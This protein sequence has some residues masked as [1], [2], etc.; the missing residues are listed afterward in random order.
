MSTKLTLIVLIIVLLVGT[1]TA[2]AQDTSPE[3]LVGINYSLSLPSSPELLPT[4]QQLISD[5]RMIGRKVST[6]RLYN[7]PDLGSTLVPLADRENIQVVLQ[8]WLTG[9]SAA[10]DAE[11]AAAIEVATANRNVIGVIVGEEVIS[12]GDLEADALVEY[13]GQ[14]RTALPNRVAVGYADQLNEWLEH[15]ELAEAVDWVG[16]DSLGFASCQTLE[17]ATR[18]TINQWAILIGTPAYQDKHV[19]ITETGWPTDGERT[20]CTSPVT[21]SPETQSEFTLALLENA[22]AAGLDVFLTSFTDEPW[23]CATEPNQRYECHWGL[24]ATDRTPKLAWEQLPVMVTAD[25]RR[26]VAVV[27]T[28]SDSANCRSEANTEASVVVGL[29]DGVPVQLIDP[30]SDEEWVLVQRQNQQCWMHHSVLTVDGRRLRPRSER[31]V[32]STENLDDYL[33]S[34]DLSQ[35]PGEDFGTIVRTTY[36]ASDVL[37]FAA[38]IAKLNTWLGDADVQQIAEV[39]AGTCAE[40][41]S[42]ATQELIDSRFRSAWALDSVASAYYNFGLSLRNAGLVKLAAEAFETVT[43]DFS[44]AWAYGEDDVNGKYFFSIP[45]LA[46]RQLDNLPLVTPP[47]ST[48]SG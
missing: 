37:V 46:Q 47:A 14:V 4:E 41:P 31:L 35:C 13:L 34:I 29:P 42:A 43:E 10:N 12:R 36:T 18:F 21:G 39:D 40:Q 8:A 1:F 24:V 44:C 23:R 28:E 5:M 27:N 25:T 33:A 7:V 26:I 3:P 9:D 11:I 2:A 17:E 16:L 30:N 45:T 32:V 6:I 48:T 15:P 19:V 22:T 38:C 20:D